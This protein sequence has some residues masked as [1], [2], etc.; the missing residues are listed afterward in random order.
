MVAE[1]DGPFITTERI[2]D[3]AHTPP[4]IRIARLSRAM[5][6]KQDSFQIIRTPRCRS[7]PVPS[8][9]RETMPK[10]CS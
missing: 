6:Q 8:G 5:R 10:D 2:L 1:E 3:E 7:P 4:T 9:I